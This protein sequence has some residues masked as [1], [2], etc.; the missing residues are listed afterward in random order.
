MNLVAGVRGSFCDVHSAVQYA[1]ADIAFRLA[2]API[3]WAITDENRQEQLSGAVE[4]AKSFFQY[5]DGKRVYSM[6]PY[7]CSW[8]K[9]MP[10]SLALQRN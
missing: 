10:H 9:W 3:G 6:R 2:L 4:K 8:T 7:A 5:F 1:I